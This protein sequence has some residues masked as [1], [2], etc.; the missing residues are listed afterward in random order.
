MVTLPL[1]ERITEDVECF[2]E[3]PNV[4]CVAAKL[5]PFGPVS[6]LHLPLELGPVAPVARDHEAHRG[7]RDGRAHGNEVRVQLDEIQRPDV[8]DG[9]IRMGLGG[10]TV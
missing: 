10:E 1:S 7:N 6:A 3:R 5:K 8:A 9:E 2:E 4:L